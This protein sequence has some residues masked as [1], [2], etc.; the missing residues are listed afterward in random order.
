M[1]N[2]DRLIPKIIDL[3]KET[4]MTDIEVTDKS[5]KIIKKQ[6]MAPFTEHININRSSK[7][8][9]IKKRCPRY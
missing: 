6:K 2:D 8:K 3:S 7:G 4:K 5:N 1:S 9:R